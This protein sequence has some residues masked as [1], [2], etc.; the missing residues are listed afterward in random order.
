MR[1]QQQWIQEAGKKGKQQ[2]RAGET[3]APTQAEG[4]AGGARQPK[5]SAS[6]LPLPKKRGLATG[7][8][9]PPLLEPPLA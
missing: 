8:I 3:T 2:T 4:C 7:V 5:Q 9:V 6:L 1:A